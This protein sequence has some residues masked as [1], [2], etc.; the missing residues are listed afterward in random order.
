M[1][2]FLISADHP[3]LEGHFQGNPIVPGVTLLQEI[4]VRIEDEWPDLRI[5]GIMRAKFIEVLKPNQTVHLVVSETNLGLKFTCHHQDT[6][7]ATGHF[8]ISKRSLE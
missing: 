1:I 5:T 7:I 3:S 6:Q 2:E 8:K 4:K